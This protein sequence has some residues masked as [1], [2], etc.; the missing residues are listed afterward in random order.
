MAQRPSKGRHVGAGK[1][2]GK[3]GSAASGRKHGRTAAAKAVPAP[4]AREDQAEQRAPG[5][6]TKSMQAARYRSTFI[7][8]RRLKQAQDAGFPDWVSYLKTLPEPRRKRLELNER[9][10]TEIMRRPMTQDEVNALRARLAAEL[11][12]TVTRTPQ[13]EGSRIPRGGFGMGRKPGGYMPK[14]DATVPLEER[15]GDD[16]NAPNFDPRVASSGERALRAAL[17]KVLRERRVRELDVTTYDL[18]VSAYIEPNRIGEWERENVTVQ[19]LGDMYRIARALGLSGEELLRRWLEAMIGRPVRASRGAGRNP[20]SQAAH[21]LV[22]E[23]AAL[24]SPDREDELLRRWRESVAFTRT[25]R[26]KDKPND[27]VLAMLSGLGAA[28]RGVADAE[29]A[30][31]REER[32][33]ARVLEVTDLIARLIKK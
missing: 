16:P 21:P 23:E 3:R 11:G 10:R 13:R 17:A 12:V 30:K 7:N 26:L 29:L 27:D 18:A 25:P 24:A 8:K 19:R 9:V 22:V 15:Q 28:L 32:S 5:P 1:Q 31:H 2:N 33:S 6:V 14:V 20:R 4:V